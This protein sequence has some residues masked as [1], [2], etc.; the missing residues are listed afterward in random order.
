[1]HPKDSSEF[2]IK[3]GAKGLQEH[4]SVCH[5]NDDIAFVKTNITKNESILDLG[6][7]Y[8]R[9]TLPLVKAGYKNIRGI[10]LASNLIT[11]A[12]KEAR[13][14]KLKVFFDV[15]SMTLLPYQNNAFDK[16]LCL[17]NSFNELLKPQDQVRA[18]REVRRVL[19]PKGEAIFIVYDG[20]CKFIKRLTKSGLL[21][22][23]KPVL[24]DTF[25]GAYIYQYIYTKKTLIRLAQKAGFKIATVKFIRLHKRRRLLLILG[26]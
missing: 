24:I 13:R 3:I 19:R 17:W 5:V 9:V 6:C 23:K 4:A 10:D 16:I 14:R 21:D 11:S 1:M 12:R 22:S 18:L 25:K 15:G 8:G 20:E 2:Y 26:K 7:G